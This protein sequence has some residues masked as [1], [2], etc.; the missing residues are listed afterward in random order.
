[1]SGSLG[2]GR[3][4]VTLLNFFL[5]W[6]KGRR[7]M[8]TGFTGNRRSGCMHGP[9]VHPNSVASG[10]TVCVICRR[11]AT[12]GPIL[13]A[14]LHAKRRESDLP[15][16]VTQLHSLKE[17]SSALLLPSCTLFFLLRRSFL[18]TTRGLRSVFKA[19]ALLAVVFLLIAGFGFFDYGD[20]LSRIKPI[21]TGIVK[22]TP[23]GV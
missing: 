10:I 5:L 15:L 11:A 9:L 7:D 6:E 21:V 20:S 1:M 3:R 2:T 17:T 12:R 8:L 22:P 14:Y 18:M 16:S 23:A 4:C 19:T 13:S